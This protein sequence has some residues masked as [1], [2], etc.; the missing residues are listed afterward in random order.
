M[1]GRD[2]GGRITPGYYSHIEV[3]FS[4]LEWTMTRTLWIILLSD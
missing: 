4:Q 1:M 2:K 3:S